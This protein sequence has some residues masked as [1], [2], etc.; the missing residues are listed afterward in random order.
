MRD[1]TS[2][3]YIMNAN[4][5]GVFSITGDIEEGFRSFGEP[6]WAPDGESIAFRYWES[7]GDIASNEVYIIGTKQNNSVIG[8]NNLSQSYAEDVAPSWSP[9]GS[10]IVFSSRRDSRPPDYSDEPPEDGEI[11]RKVVWEIYVMN[12]DGTEQQRLTYYLAFSQRPV[13]SPDGTRI[14]FTTNRDGGNP[15]IY[16]LN[17]ESGEFKRL[18]D[19]QHSDWDPVWSPDSRCI[20]VTSRIDDNLDIYVLDANTGDIIRRLT[21]DPADDRLPDW[22]PAK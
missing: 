18:T 11:G 15:E 10:R 13:W 19:N 22:S 20:A 4:G 1:G 16:V 2:E 8:L 17:I 6:D 7:S 21:T 9:D 12:V 3:I 14:A 5:T